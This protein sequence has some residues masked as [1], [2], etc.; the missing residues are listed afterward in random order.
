MWVAILIC[1]VERFAAFLSPFMLRIPYPNAR[2][3]FSLLFSGL[4]LWPTTDHLSPATYRWY[5]GSQPIKLT[6][7][8]CSSY[9]HL[10]ACLPWWRD[11]CLFRTWCVRRPPGHR[12]WSFNTG[13][14]RILR[15]PDMNADWYAAIARKC[16]C[17]AFPCP[18]RM[19]RYYSLS[20][21]HYGN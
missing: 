3:R 6:G 12:H 11:R 1:Q 21:Y 20:R 9:Y 8:L 19:Y 18:N 13:G 10:R 7:W 16:V 15:Y 14:G 2:R 5:K 17:F 4:Y